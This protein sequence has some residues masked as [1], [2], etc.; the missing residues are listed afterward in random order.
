MLPTLGAGLIAVSRIMDA[1]HHPFDVISGGLLGCL[2]AW[3]SYRQYFPP[4]HEAWRRGRAYPIR[5]WGTMPVGPE[6]E[7]AAREKARD[8]GVE[9]MRSGALGG[10]VPHPFDEEDHAPIINPGAGNAFRQTLGETERMR[11]EQFPSAS[12]PATSTAFPHNA[13]ATTGGLAPTQARNRGGAGGQRAYE[14]PG[15]WSSSED[16]ESGGRGRREGEGYELQPQYTLSDPSGSGTAAP[17]AY[18]SPKVP[19]AGTGRAAYAP[20]AGT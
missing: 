2:T 7:R 11:Q 20:Y 19:A 13:A 18:V 1:R 6:G 4:I 10:L 8:Q 3:V 5:S 16:G 15:D 17:T 12:A 14:Q 9:P